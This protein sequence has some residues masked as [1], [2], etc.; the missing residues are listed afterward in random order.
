M[1]YNKEKD[2][3]KRYLTEMEVEAYRCELKKRCFC[4]GDISEKVFLDQTLDPRYRREK[5]EMVFNQQVMITKRERERLD[6]YCTCVIVTEDEFKEYQTLKY[7]KPTIKKICE[8]YNFDPEKAVDVVDEIQ[9]LI[10]D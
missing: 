8:K 7:L 6:F 9:M 4:L 2:T 3:K 1:Y 10:F 5:L